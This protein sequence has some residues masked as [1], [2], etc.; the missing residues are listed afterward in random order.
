MTGNGET[1]GFIANLLD[2]QQSRGLCFQFPFEAILRQQQGF[3][4]RFAGGSLG[5][6]NYLHINHAQLGQHGNRSAHLPL[7]AVDQQNIW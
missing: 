7:A 1:V 6:A 5:D 3:K 4:T 2:K